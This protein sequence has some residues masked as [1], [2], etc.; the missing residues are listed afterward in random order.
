MPS[1]AEFGYLI[2]VGALQAATALVVGLL[3]VGLYRTSRELYLRYWGAAWL[4]LSALS[5][6][7]VAALMIGAVDRGPGL[8][9]GLTSVAIGYLQPAGLGLAA[10]S[11]ARPRLDTRRAHARAGAGILAALV[12]VVLAG[13]LPL[14]M[15]TRALLAVVPSH[16]ASASTTAWLAWS[17]ARNH[18]HARTLPGRLV[19]GFT[20]AYALHLFLN[21]LAWGGY[22]L[23]SH[24]TLAAV[25]GVLLPMGITAGIALS[26]LQDLARTSA[27]LHE[28]DAVNRGLIAEAERA[29]GELAAK[30]AELERFT[31]TVSH[32]LRSPLVTILGFTGFADAALRAGD[33]GGARA[34]LE[35]IRLAASRME[36][37]LRSVLE[38]SRVGRL[39]AAPQ[40]CDT[41]AIA[42]EVAQLLEGPARECR[43]QVEVCQPLPDVHADPLRVRQLLQNLVENALR[44]SCGTERPLVRIGA[45]GRAPDGWVVLFVADNGIGIAPEDQERVF[46]L[47]EKLDPRGE[48]TGI[49]LA[50][51]RRIAESYGGRAWVESAGAGHGAAFCVTLPAAEPSAMA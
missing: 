2:T 32:D 1:F 22:E 47:F 39:T 51:V 43:A 21:S 29:N 36:Q 48:G 33:A 49:G 40:R 42:R 38:L 45:R 50:L 11:L 4:A 27:R 6:I 34:D 20:G 12:P 37:M 31:Y 15:R 18:P 16:L 41:A 46:G 25:I 30:N 35:R 14:E 13:V 8:V 9:V 26:M 24:P 7:G 28:A 3:L 17:F 10:A 5:I 19:V 23:Y 44:F